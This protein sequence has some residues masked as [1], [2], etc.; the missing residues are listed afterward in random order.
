MTIKIKFLRKNKN[1]EE[2][3]LKTK[4]KTSKTTINFNNKIIKGRL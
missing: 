2:Q 1:R 4:I 3:F